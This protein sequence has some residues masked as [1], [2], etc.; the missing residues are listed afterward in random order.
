MKQPTGADAS[1]TQRD[2]GVAKRAPGHRSKVTKKA[3]KLK[4]VR[5]L[6]AARAQDKASHANDTASQ[7][8]DN[9]SRRAASPGK[10]T[11]V[12]GAAA[13]K[14]Q[15]AP[16]LSTL[17]QKMQQKLKGARF[18]WINEAMYTTTGDQTYEMV[19]KDPT[20]FE[21]YHEGFAAQVRKWPVNPVDVFIKRLEHR[22]PLVVA[23]M[24]CGEAALA[25]AVG[26]RHTVHSFDLVAHNKLITPCNIAD[27]PLPSGSVD[28]AVF[29]LALMG[30]D[31]ISFIR[32][33]NRI[34]RTG[35]ELKIAEVVSRIPDMDAFVRALAD[36]GF[37]L[38]RKE[39]LSKMFVVLEMAK[40]RL[41]PPPAKDGSRRDLLKPCVYKRR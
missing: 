9:P 40:K 21:E 33:A 12:A 19:Q 13:A 25:A 8:N 2:G 16:G 10:R 14:R 26:T 24:G 36:Q 18:R 23:D 27:V 30:T 1:R 15:P 7:S 37:E 35:G 28:V 32:E 20:I 4:R 6:L 39:T 41:P 5:D 22:E 38:I 17:Q 31:F 34:L 3:E 11:L 29:C